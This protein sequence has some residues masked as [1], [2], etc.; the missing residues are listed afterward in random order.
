MIKNYLPNK[1]IPA[2]TLLENFG[3]P[4]DSTTLFR[5]FEIAGLIEKI[6]YISSSGSGEIKTFWAFT[7]K[8]LQFGENKP[9][10]SPT[11]TNLA[12]Y[13]ITFHDA[14]LA[15]AEVIMAHTRSLQNDW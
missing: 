6:E 12:F 8:G 10:L 1:T 14:L 4:M 9:T 11:K 3:S 7:D 2:K 13:P 15:A 5:A